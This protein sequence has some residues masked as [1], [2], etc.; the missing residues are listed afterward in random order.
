VPAGVRPFDQG[1]SI[2]TRAAFPAGL[3]TAFTRF[4]ANDSPVS[5]PIHGNSLQRHVRANAP[6]FQFVEIN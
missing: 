4:G 2:E 6:R 1:A 5:S 3:F